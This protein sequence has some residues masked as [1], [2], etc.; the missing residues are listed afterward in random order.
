MCRSVGLFLSSG[1]CGLE[2]DDDDVGGARERAT[3]SS[4][5]VRC[6]AHAGCSMYGKEEKR[7]RGMKKKNRFS[8]KNY[9][10]LLSVVE[11]THSAHRT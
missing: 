5:C 6:G 4:E 3:E 8:L 9:E 1:G 2:L 11:P 10:T 7:E